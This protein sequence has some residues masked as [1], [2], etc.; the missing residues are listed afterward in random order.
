MNNTVRVLILEHDSNDVELL[1]CELKKGGLNFICETVE[2]REDFE[3]ALK[4]F[5]P[6]IIL[7]DYSLPSFDGKKAFLIKE[8][9]SSGIPFIIVSGL[10]GEENAVEL[11]K[12]GVTDY[13]L[14]DKLFAVVPKI[15][16]A[17]KEAR[18]QYDKKEQDKK[19]ENYSR[20]LER[21]NEELEQFAY[22]AS[23][24]L[25]EPL[26]MVGSFLQL[27][28]KKYTDKLDA[29]A[30]EF[31]YYA[32]DGAARMKRLIIDLLNYSRLNKDLVM[33]QVDLSV[34]IREALVNLTTSII[35]N[36]AVINFESMPVL[37]ADPS[38]M[39]QLF[40]NLIGN[41]IKYRKDQ[42]TPIVNIRAHNEGTHWLFAIEDNGIGIEKQYADKIFILFKQLHDKAK[43]NGTGIGLAMVKKIVESHLGKIWFESENGEGT[44]FYFTL[45]NPK[46]YASH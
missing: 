33:Q 10:I 12:A 24:D 31:I 41:A 36:D 2:T 43:Y 42:F 8:E 3:K 20:E 15:N 23:H 45:H 4:N 17:L 38:Q 40:Q 6:E 11:I 1:Q 32:V 35:E 21:S 37:N 9:F 26:R 16:R 18:E 7:A 14:K 5:N 28:Q 22:V 44:T 34:S 13:V 46:I 29:E 30:N 25:Q 27:L 39:L 19:L